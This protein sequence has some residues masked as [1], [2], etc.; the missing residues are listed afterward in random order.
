MEGIARYIYET[1]IRLIE[2]NP[3]DQFFLVFD[4][5]IDPGL[6]SKFPSNAKFLVAH[7]QARHPILFYIWFEHALPRLF[8]KH[9]IDLFYSPESFLSLKANVPTLIVTHDIA[10]ET[11]RDHLPKTIQNYL[12]RNGPKFHDRADH[13]VAVSDFTR[14]DIIKQYKVSPDKISIAGNATPDGFKPINEIEKIKVRKRYSNGDNFLL[15]VG[16][17]HPRKNIDRLIEAFDHFNQD[18]TYTL[19]LIGRMAWETSELIK[20]IDDNEKV[21][22]LANIGPEL[23]TIMAA[24]DLLCY[25]SLFEGFGI[26][27]LE[28]MSCKVPVLTSENSSMSEVGGDAAYYVNPSSAESIASGIKTILQD[29]NLRLSMIAKGEKRINDF[30]WD[31]TSKLIEEQLFKLV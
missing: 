19:L 14:Q 17:I 27:L 21:I 5:A 7:P 8:K 13:V 15:Y 9:N 2:N 10:F 26:P 16:A 20:K 23:K 4:R 29:E 12:V 6:K 24:A 31:I 25:V 30:S 28:A 1:S 3:A 11:Y 22:H 18:K